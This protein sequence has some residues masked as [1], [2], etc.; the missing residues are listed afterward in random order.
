QLSVLR[1]SVRKRKIY[2]HLRRNR[3]QP[4][5]YPARLVEQPHMGIA[6]REISVGVRESRVG[7]DR[8]PQPWDCLRELSV[9]EQSGA[10]Q[11]RASSSARARAE[12]QSHRSVLDREI[13]L[14]GPQSEKPA[15]VPAARKARIESKSAIDQRDHRIEIFAENR[16]RHCGVGQNARVVPGDLDGPASKLDPLWAD[17]IAIRDVEV[18]GQMLAALRRKPKGGT[19]TGVA[20]NGLL[21]QR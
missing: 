8:N 17:R 9:Q 20:G 19:V 11:I 21:K 7:L 1:I 3:A 5:D 14:A 2:H 13:R 10:D 12:A 16:E 15:D 6:S 4:R 18:R